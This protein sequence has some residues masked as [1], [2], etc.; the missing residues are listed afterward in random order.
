MKYNIINNLYFL[1]FRRAK[2]PFVPFWPL[3]RLNVAYIGTLFTPPGWWRSAC[4]HGLHHRE[5][6]FS[7]TPLDRLPRTRAQSQSPLGAQARL[8]AWPGVKCVIC[9]GGPAAKPC[10]RKLKKLKTPL[11]RLAQPTP[12]IES[13]VELSVPCRSA[14]VL[15]AAPIG[16]APFLG[17]LPFARGRQWHSRQGRSR[18]WF[19]ISH[20]LPG[21]S[22]QHRRPARVTQPRSALRRLR[23]AK[24]VAIRREGAM[25]SLDAGSGRNGLSGAARGR[26]PQPEALAPGAL[27]G[28]GCGPAIGRSGRQPRRPDG[29][30]NLQSGGVIYAPS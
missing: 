15:T 22:A 23:A 16:R 11:T 28:T 25:I 20:Q 12:A 30:C 4:R 2:I 19:R 8:K 29:A 21:L 9:F 27:P 6:L 24:A 26:V 5:F 1:D 18:E 7:A 17:P 13:S 10:A 3:K 14:S